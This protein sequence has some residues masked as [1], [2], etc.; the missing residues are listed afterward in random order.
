MW[1]SPRQ[2]APRLRGLPPPPQEAAPLQRGSRGSSGSTHPWAVR[3]LSRQKA[4]RCSRPH[5]T[6]TP[7]LARLAPAGALLCPGRPHWARRALP[8]A[9][10]P[11]GPGCC[12]SLAPHP[13]LL[14][15]ARATL[16]ILIPD[17]VKQ[18]SEEKPRDSEE[19]EV[20]LGPPLASGRG[21]LPVSAGEG[22]PPSRS[23][24]P[25]L[26]VGVRNCVCRTARKSRCAESC[27]VD[28]PSR[29]RLQKLDCSLC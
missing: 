19:L 5:G 1:P 9:A 17:F 20:S 11:L 3:R 6:P 14:L 29:Q 25:C 2:A 15:A 27:A 12:L 21:G 7:T 4:V 13:V 22:C 10:P 26:A 16:E 18:T 24:S 8:S 28:E 23:P